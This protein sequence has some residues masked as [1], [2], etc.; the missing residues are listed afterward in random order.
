VI[1]AT[2]ELYR[3]RLNRWSVAWRVLLANVP[4]LILYWIFVAPWVRT[5][6]MAHVPIPR[7]QLGSYI[8]LVA[9][10]ASVAALVL[11]LPLY[12]LY[13]D[14]NWRTAWAFGLGGAAIPAA[15][16]LVI[17]FSP[18]G[19]GDGFGHAFCVEVSDGFLTNCGFA[20]LGI[21][22]AEA[23]MYGALSGLVFWLLLRWRRRAD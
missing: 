3:A 10:A 12:L 4:A 14:R 22:V 19:P 20:N 18:R 21:N 23:A 2:A 9:A 5:V 13:R 8:A 7:D 1:I 15:I 11:G 6:A 16:L 17:G